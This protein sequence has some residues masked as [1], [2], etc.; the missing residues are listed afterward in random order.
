MG[1]VLQ[2]YREGHGNGILVAHIVACVSPKLEFL[3][4]NVGLVQSK[5]CMQ[6]L[7]VLVETICHP[8]WPFGSAVWYNQSNEV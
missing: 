7:S 1:I 3:L 8:T 2:G 5:A 4:Q 6:P